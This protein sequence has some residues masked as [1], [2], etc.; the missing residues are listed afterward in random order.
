MIKLFSIAFSLT[1][2]LVFIPAS[3]R[4]GDLP[5]AKTPEPSCDVSEEELLGR[6][7]AD[8]SAMHARGD[9]MDAEYSRYISLGH[10]GKDSLSKKT[11]LDAIV[12]MINSVS[13]GN[14]LVEL[15]PVG[16]DGNLFRIDIR[17]LGWN[18]PAGRGG[19]LW[20]LI[21]ERNPY[22]KSQLLSPRAAD[23][24]QKAG[25]KNAVM[26][27]GDWF[28]SAA[29]KPPLYYR[30]TGTPATMNELSADLRVRISEDLAAGNVVRAGVRQSEA[31]RN[32]RESEGNRRITRYE[33]ENGKYFW[34]AANLNDAKEARNNVALNP[35]GANYSNAGVI[36]QLPN[37]MPAY[38]Q[39]DG[40]GQRVDT[41]TSGVVRDPQLPNGHMVTGVSCIRCHANGIIPVE[42]GVRPYANNR[43]P[44][45]IDEINKREAS[46]IAS[47]EQGFKKFEEKEKI[48]L[49]GLLEPAQANLNNWKKSYEESQSPAAKEQEE[50]RVAALEEKIA[51]SRSGLA[52]IQD[53]IEKLRSQMRK[54]PEM[55]RKKM[56]QSARD[57]IRREQREAE[58]NN[59]SVIAQIKKLR[60]EESLKQNE[61]QTASA[62]KAS[63]IVDYTG[64]I[65][66][67]EA[68]I[69]R[70]R[71]EFSRNLAERR[72]QIDEREIPSIQSK[73][74]EMRLAKTETLKK[75]N[76]QFKP[77]AEINKAIERDNRSLASKLK[78]L[79]ITGKTD[80]VWLTA[81]AFESDVDLYAFACEVGMPPDQL[82]ALIGSAPEKLQELTSFLVD[83]SAPRESTISNLHT[84]RK[85]KGSLEFLKAYGTAKEVM[86][87]ITKNL[88]GARSPE[89]FL[90]LIDTGPR[91]SE[92]PE[93]QRA[94]DA[95]IAQRAQQWAELM[96][97][98]TD[99]D[100][101]QLSRIKGVS[102]GTMNKVRGAVVD[103]AN[104]RAQ[105][106]EAERQKRIQEDRDR[107]DFLKKDLARASSGTAF[108]LKLQ[109]HAIVS[110]DQE[111]MKGLDQLVS[112]RA[113]QFAETI[114]SASEMRALKATR[115]LTPQ[116]IEKVERAVNISRARYEER[117][118]ARQKAA[119]QA[120]AARATRAEIEAAI[121]ICESRISSLNYSSSRSCGSPITVEGSIFMVPVLGLRDNSYCYRSASAASEALSK[122]KSCFDSHSSDPRECDCANGYKERSRGGNSG[123]GRAFFD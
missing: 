81:R 39:F 103:L 29:S 96:P 105:A 14:G 64:E 27:Q 22:D 41:E 5:V 4:G 89:D 55:P 3:A 88:D 42:D 35:I 108:V 87:I 79:N 114:P 37:G 25:T 73:Y 13:R 123:R 43:I 11:R 33:G 49:N 84:L 53:Q 57:E 112:E 71:G 44:L 74:A 98:A 46:E 6:I 59:D 50:K 67:A 23:I 94:I 109:Q 91:L 115:G 83:C 18:Q 58:K 75:I 62:N 56:K 102:S 80:P 97:P 107:V 101:A 66:K 52:E 113:E 17:K 31:E 78:D 100:M 90:S 76:G 92:D 40:S 48:R 12:K 34:I 118:R 45:E 72:K 69:Q 119:A 16:K 61:V 63:K 19:N 121:S 99:N 2:C 47:V 36:Y 54:V 8:L 28:V 7:D 1:L 117:E 85:L 32:Q 38:A 116:T 20:D 106:A 122:Q 51:Q 110:D 15:I 86:P 26:M 65:E 60:S 120:A 77:Q 68:H 111:A 30:L 95:L 21:Q 10:S 93:T 24:A 104:K 82:A 70:L 9:A